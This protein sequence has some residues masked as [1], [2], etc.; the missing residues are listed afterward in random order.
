MRSLP[1]EM[2]TAHTMSL[3]SASSP[4]QPSALLAALLSALVPGAGQWYLGK[5][6]RALLL[7]TPLVV[8]VIAAG[9]YKG[10]VSSTDVIATLVQPRNLTGLIAGNIVVVAWRLYAVGDAYWLASGDGRNR[11]IVLA[12][13][14]VLVVLVAVPHLIAGAYTLRTIDVLNSVFVTDDTEMPTA[15]TL[16]LAQPD[17][18]ATP[19]PALDEEP[20][21]HP[22]IINRPPS[23][24]VT[25]EYR[26]IGLIFKDGVGDPDAIAVQRELRTGTPAAPFVDFSDRVDEDR[27][28]ILL[29]GGDRGPGRDGLRTDTMIVATVDVNTGHAALFGIPRN[30]KRVPLG[31]DFRHAFDELALELWEWEPDEDEDGFPDDWVDLDGDEIPDM[32]ELHCHCYPDLLNHLQGDTRDWTTSFPNSPD[33]GMDTLAASLGS[34][35]GLEID[36]WMLV[37]MRGFVQLIDAMGGVDVMVTDG[38]HVGVSPSED[39]LPKAIVNVEPGPAHLTGSE[40]LAYVRWRKGSSDYVRMQRQRCLLR[41]VAAEADP[42]TMLRSFTAMAD[43]IE[44]S[45][46]TNIPLN[47]LPDLVEVIG[48]IDLNQIATVGLVPPRYTNGRTPGGYPIPDV[49]RMRDEVASVLAEGVQ[50]VGD[51]VSEGECGI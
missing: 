8:L 18:T 2:D 47:F 45:V 38:L 12:G 26:S 14:G 19:D 15:T 41:S 36:Y 17:E 34:M 22:E 49:D 44:S 13:L 1:G 6:R 16:I 5:R 7:F 27:I 42:L 35:I 33:P 46:V 11:P 43:A 21:D 37:D 40:A 28:T 4:H 48:T 20:D 9:L 3:S 23:S 39:G 50:G 32:P 24:L 31:E 25:V 29:A 51:L 10:S 30:L